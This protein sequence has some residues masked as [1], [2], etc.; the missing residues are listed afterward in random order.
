MEKVCCTSGSPTNL[1]PEFGMVFKFRPISP[2]FKIQDWELDSRFLDLLSSNVTWSSL[3]QTPWDEHILAVLFLTEGHEWAVN[4]YSI[5]GLNKFVFLSQVYVPKPTAD[6]KVPLSRVQY[7]AVIMKQAMNQVIGVMKGTWEVVL[8]ERFAS[9]DRLEVDDGT[10][11]F[12]VFKSE[13]EIR[14]YVEAVG[15]EDDADTSESIH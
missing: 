11:D 10:D 6:P 15:L 14:Q 9:M 5:R 7:Q 13:E 2:Y 12:L 3:I 1:N 8:R 4:L